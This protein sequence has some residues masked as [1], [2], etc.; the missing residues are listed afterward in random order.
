MSNDD[1]QFDDNNAAPKDSPRAENTRSE[2]RASDREREDRRNDREDDYDDDRRGGRGRGRNSERRAWNMGSLGRAQSRPHMGGVSDA[3]LAALIDTFKEAKTFE[4]PAIE[5]EIQQSKFQVLPYTGRSG[6]R[7]QPSLLVCLPL[8]S[9]GETL[10]YA[11]VIEQPGAQSTRSAVSKGESYDALVLPEDR[12]TDAYIKGLCDTA[13]PLGYKKVTLVGQQVVLSEVIRDAGEKENNRNIGALYDNAIGAL[14]QYRQNRLD[15]VT[16]DRNSEYRLTPDAVERGDRLECSIEYNAPFG[17]DTSGLPIRTD[18]LVTVYYSERTEDDVDDL[19]ERIPMVETRVGLD[20]FIEDEDEGSRRRL[21]RRSNRRR[22]DDDEEGFMQPVIN[23]QS[24]ASV[25]NYPFSLELVGLALG[26]V[27]LLSNDYRWTNMAR[28]R[29]TIGGRLKP[30]FQLADLIWLSSLD[31]D[32]KREAYDMMT[33]NID[34]DDF[35]Q[36][37]DATCKQDPTFGMMTP[38]SGERSWVLSIFER[39]ATAETDDEADKLVKALFDSWDTL[40]G[41]RFRKAYRAHNDGSMPLPVFSAGTRGL[42]GTWTDPD[43]N[44]LRPLTEWNVVAVL[45]RFAGKDLDIVRDFQYTYE[46]NRHSVDYNIS[47]RA[48]MLKKFVPDM[49][50]VTTGEQLVFH[51]TLFPALAEALDKCGLSSYISSGDTLHG[52]KRVGNRLF[53]SQSVSDAGRSRRSGRD[54]DDR[55]GRSGRSWFTDGSGY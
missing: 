37:V 12:M 43:T 25:D 3:A 54:R 28:P 26:N 11:L 35:G 39:I 15:R 10:V 45:T 40:T 9:L 27:A 13:V 22:D 42:I 17:T 23:I 47:E 31:D 44:T 1:L 18:G 24:I 21:S 30:T 7:G 51:K 46:Q 48:A 41:N 29:K 55:G 2:E 32:Q 52:R 34:D 53:S 33:P 49:R 5:G 20:M 38:S 6:G 19:Y 36:F 14:C 8:K 4:N 50:V 16:G